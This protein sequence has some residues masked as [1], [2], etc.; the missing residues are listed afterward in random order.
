VFANPALLFKKTKLVLANLRKPLPG[1]RSQSKPTVL[2]LSPGDRVRVKS[3]SEIQAT[4]DERGR[5]GGLAFMFSEMS[6]HCG[7]TY[8]VHKTVEMFFDE[9]TRR[10]IKLRNVVLLKEVFCEP[11][12]DSG[13][14]YAG[15]DRSCFL[16]WKE[17]WLERDSTE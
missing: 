15:C 17:A 13:H 1:E 2:N 14:D 5:C 6:K 7:G 4:L 3:L 11:A 12:W 8:A 9:R 10:F 16:F